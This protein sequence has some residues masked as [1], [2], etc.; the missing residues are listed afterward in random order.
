MIKL[1]QK[2]RPPAKATVERQRQG[3]LAVDFTSS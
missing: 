3:E 2:R 1:V